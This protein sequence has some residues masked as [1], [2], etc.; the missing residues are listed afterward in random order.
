MIAAF[1]KLKLNKAIL[2]G[3]FKNTIISKTQEQEGVPR[4]KKKKKMPAK[5]T[6]KINLNFPSGGSIKDYLVLKCFLINIW[7]EHVGD[8]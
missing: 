4:F 3:F 6:L 7:L 2:T 8:F 1:Y 5:N